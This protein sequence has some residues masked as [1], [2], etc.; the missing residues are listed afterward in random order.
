[1]WLLLSR[2]HVEMGALEQAENAA[3]EAL[4][5]DPQNPRLERVSNWIQEQRKLQNQTDPD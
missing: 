2:T 3:R 1:M 5:R 4:K